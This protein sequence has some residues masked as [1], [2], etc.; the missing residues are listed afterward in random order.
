MPDGSKADMSKAAWISKT[1]SPIPEKCVEGED[2][3]T[4]CMFVLCILTRAVLQAMPGML[5]LRLSFSSCA[6]AIESSAWDVEGCAWDVGCGAL[7]IE[8]SAW[9][10]EGGVWDVDGRGWAAR[11][12]WG[13]PG[14]LKAAPGL[15]RALPGLLTALLWMLMA[16]AC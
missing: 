11:F 1:A 7:A 10:V 8:S 12:G 6:W 5:K 3:G 13:L 2:L 15:L 9:D 4:P 14:M 16:C